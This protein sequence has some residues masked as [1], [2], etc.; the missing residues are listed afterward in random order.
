MTENVTGA[1]LATQAPHRGPGGAPGR[2]REPEKARRTVRDDRPVTLTGLAVKVVLLGLVAGIA[3]W[4][5]FPLVEAEA[6]LG[7]GILVA[8]TAGLFYLYLSRRHIP[9]K[10]LVPGTL[11]LIVFQ[12]F[13][14]LY[15]ASTA[16]T[17]FGDGHRGSKDDAIVA[18]QSS[19]VVQVPGSIE[20]ALSI[21][22]TGDAATGPLVFLV[23]DPATGTVSAGDADGLEPLDAG[24]VTVNSAGKV[25]AADGY[26]VLNA[27]QASARSQ[28][29]TEFAVPTEGGAIRSAG[30]S[31]AYEGKA[32]RAYDAGCDCVRDA[33]SGKVWTADPERG[34]FVA[35]DGE[36]LL[37]GWRVN[38]GLSNFTRVLTEPSISGPF[39]ETLIWNFGFAIGS[40]FVTFA[41]GLLCALALHSPRV[42]GRTLYRVLL[43]LPYAMPSF[44]MLL[45][46]RD[47]FNTDFGLVN[48][49]F[50]LNVDWMGETWS[51]RAAVVLV[52][53][54]LGYP[55]M[56]LV[57]TG[58]LQAI[59]R[60]LTEATSVDGASPWQ[61]FRQ[62]TLPLL[63][64]A[65]TPLLISSFAYNF[66]NFNAIHLTTG[67]GP[68]PAD[69]P[70]VGAT[71]LLI[72][73]TYRLAFGA[74]G[75]E[76]GFAAA[77]SIFIFTLVA[78]ISAIS[79]R[80]SRQQE[81]VYA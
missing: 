60:E 47:M 12:V 1:G 39:L 9:A 81:E 64:V 80:R 55:Y 14:V 43:I 79:F 33:E 20:Y 57:A 49:L 30:L 3:L 11:F 54:W 61:S 59:P 69:N 16:F 34:A 45:V 78:V 74:A 42:R 71:D 73:Y 66:N 6:W 8:T 70:S 50:G 19:S 72:T 13:P 36:R 27:G 63:L 65:L 25:T 76:Y 62:I 68:F 7:L 28:E 24:S 35:A 22:T 4:A 18:I 37:Q 29:I 53:L 44:A 52:Q 58:A 46:W 67:G 51:A 41:L 38:V 2:G 21:A 10:Y 56:F 31:R 75:A 32:T 40:V 23:T 48:N 77:I 15:T 5:A 26:T 17:N